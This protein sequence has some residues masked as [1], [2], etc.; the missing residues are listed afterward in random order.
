M[1]SRS[2]ADAI[3]E[4][5]RGLVEEYIVAV[6]TRD[7]IMV[8]YANGEVTVTQAWRDYITQVYMAK[9]GKV[10][11][12]TFTS[13]DPV[14]A[15]A[16]TVSLLEKLQ[17]SPLYA[18]LPQP[19]G[20]PS[21]TVNPVIRDLSLAGDAAR[22][23][24]DV[25]VSGYGN[26]AG[27]SSLEYSN[28]Y[29]VGSNGLDAGFEVTSFSGYMR[30]FRGESSGQW[31]WV[32]TEYE[33]TL[34]LKAIDKAVELANLCSNLPQEKIAS[35]VYRVLLS[36]MIAG[37][38]M[39]RV[40][41][42]ASAG[43]VVLGFSFLQGRRREEVIASDKLTLK[44]VPLEPSLPGY[45]SLDDEGVATRNKSVIEKGVFKGFLHNTKTARL[46]GEE[47]TGNAGWILPRIFNLEIEGGSL[48]EEELLEA[49]GDG[50][51]ATNNW[52]TRFQNYLEGTFS[53]VT[54]DALIVVRGGRP[55]AC[56]RRA[57]L[58]GRLP[59]LIA[60][61]EDLSR[62]RWPIQWWEVDIPFIIP[63]ILVSKLGL[64]MEGSIT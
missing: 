37:N 58:T 26:I 41:F 23:V 28:V 12:S 42:A 2:V 15:V 4:R 9:D 31:A 29:T 46:M 64:T 39:E 34:A 43:S 25:D 44:E 53:T 33:P 19:S 7:S 14:E 10:T 27:M 20:K 24:E 8:K 63:H 13:K 5:I 18:P 47:S 45:R 22:L 55:R 38:L 60:S 3:V 59:E 51:Y 52:Y 21:S 6:T 50:V 62:E 54:R 17:P 32:S 16:R 56:A 30:V 11:A 48:R 49:L 61:I 40:A 36:P 57:R 1:S 35:G